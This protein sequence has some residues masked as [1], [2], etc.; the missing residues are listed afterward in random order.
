MDAFVTFAPQK[1][2]TRK[3]LHEEEIQRLVRYVAEGRSVF[4][5]GPTGS[6]KSFVVES[7]LNASN[8]LELDRRAIS[9]EG[10]RAHVLIDGYDAAAHRQLVERV[11]HGP[12]LVVTAGDVHLL[13]HFKLIVMPRRSPERIASLAPPGTDPAAALAAAHRSRGNVRDFFDYLAHSDTKDVFKTSKDIIAEILC[14][15]GPFDFSQTVHEHGHVCDVIHGNYLSSEGCDPPAVMESLSL[16][17]VYDSVMYRGAWEC[18]PYYVASGIAV[19]KHHM[20][21][22]IAPETLRPGS[23]WTKYNNCKMR[24]QKLKNI[25]S[26]HSTRLGVEE[27]ALVRRYAAAGDLGPLVEYG[28]TASDLDVMNHLA[29]GNK[30][31]PN[32]IVRLKKK[33]RQEDR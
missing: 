14:A 5:C 4:V 7:V 18:M 27:L 15:P 25:Q 3:T 20:G 30:M 13:P 33:M 1:K 11:P 28:L 23:A 16:A 19:P 2:E 26:R 9:F 8:S 32:E 6:G 31:R 10:T 12:P 29:L 24:Q 17:A 22:G 21:A